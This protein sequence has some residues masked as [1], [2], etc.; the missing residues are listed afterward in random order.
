MDSRAISHCI[1]GD[2]AQIHQGDVIHYH[3]K[4]LQNGV[5]ACRNA[6]F[7]TDPIVD[8]ETLKSTKGQRTAGTCEW[9]RHNETYKSWLDGDVQPLWISGDPGKGKTMLSIFLTEELE[10]LTQETEDAKLLFY[11]CSHQD[12]KRNGA[13][14]VLRGLVYQLVTKR[15]DLFQHVS[16]YFESPGKT[17]ET[18][19]SV[20]TLWIVLRKLLQA[21]LGT[22]FCALDGLDECDEASTRL[23][24]AKFRD[25]F[26]SERSKRP[27][28]GFKLVIV[29][30]KIA[31]LDAFSQVKLDPDNDEHV[32][33][34]IQQ[35]I[36]A[37]VQELERVQGFNDIRETVEATLLSRA[38]GTFL[39]VGFVMIE[40]SMKKT[41]TEIMKALDSL[42]RGL[43]AIYSR[44]LPQTESS[45]RLIISEILR[46]V[47]MAVRPLTLQE[48]MA[49]IPIPSTQSISSNQAIRDY[50]TLC[51]P[52]LKIHDQH[53]NLVHQS[54]RDYLLREDPD[55]DPILE[56]FR[57]KAGEAHSELARACLDCI[58][59]SDLRH[60]SLDIKKTSVQQKSPLL[61][62]AVLHW[63]EHARYS[64][65]FAD[66][67]F[68]L[69]RP[70]FQKKSIVRDNWWKTYRNNKAPWA[71]SNLSLLHMACYFGIE[72]L[73]RKLLLKKAWNFKF[74]KLVDKKDAALPWAA[75]GGH[76]AIVKLLLEQGADVNAMDE[77]GRSAL[78]WA[79]G[80][81]HE[82]IVKLLLE[83]GAD[84]KSARSALSSAA[85]GGHEAIVKLLLEQGAD[86]N[87]KHEVGSSALSSAALGGHEAIVKLLLEQGADVKSARSAL[88]S[89]AWGGHEA[90]VKLLLEQG[91][92]V[93]S[94]RSAL[95]S[96]A[97]GGH[98]VIVKLLKSAGAC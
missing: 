93:K 44:M 9:I 35:F 81:G 46:W 51:G 86:V 3:S 83:Q 94:D 52:I 50:I 76:E 19:S 27:G 69:S 25:F 97:E 98:E 1:F 60:Q 75:G 87:A 89:A 80:R 70:F 78:G 64:S 18:L 31:G 32:S 88:S 34:D 66:K 61:N 67:D 6:L 39:W 48:L 71:S 14:A 17:Q 28:G 96:A 65:T 84:V 77:L 2:Q 91:A 47:T 23:L 63:L 74:R 13:V 82:A 68:G 20:E 56:E 38:D 12:E 55:K 22:V 49:A 45:E 4:P 40:L 33:G 26:S 10:R 8:R 29:S 43:P 95:S 72:S 11:F 53:V 54:T 58:E 30:R 21:N 57:I 24:V 5:D 85:E 42:P 37:S 41:C 62:Y 59:K 16:S 79:A 90:I 7:L 92:D 73:A 15:R 36:S